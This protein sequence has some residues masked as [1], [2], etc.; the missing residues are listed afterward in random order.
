MSAFPPVTAPRIL[1]DISI[2]L[3]SAIIVAGGFWA[4]SPAETQAARPA[5]VAGKPNLNGIW[6]ALNTANYDILS[7]SAKA[8]LAML[9]QVDSLPDIAPLA[10]A[11]AGP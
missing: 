11:L 6:Q 3:A 1:R 8:A 5:R 9:W 4:A 2:A 7:H 10:E